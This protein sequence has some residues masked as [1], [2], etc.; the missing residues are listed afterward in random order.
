M[1]ADRIA[2]LTPREL[3]CLRRVLDFKTSDAIG[4]ELGISTHTVDT[5]ISNLCKKLHVSSR[6]DAAKLLRESDGPWR[7]FGSDIPPVDYCP[8]QRETADTE[9]EREVRL[10]DAAAERLEATLERQ[11]MAVPARQEAR[12]NDLTTLQRLALI[13][14]IALGLAVMVIAAAPMAESFKALANTIEPFHDN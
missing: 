11:L 2:T 5:H 3:E 14:T 9:V 1:G 13:A 10:R 4:Y 7:S 6:F 12:G 8:G